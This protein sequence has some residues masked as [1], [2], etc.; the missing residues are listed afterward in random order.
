MSSVVLLITGII[1]T[2]APEL[3]DHES[4]DALRNLRLKLIQDHPARRGTAALKQFVYLPTGA[5]APRM[6][7]QTHR[8][9]VTSASAI[10]A[11]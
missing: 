5:C 7:K 3:P 1:M 4:L 10:T 9:F 8:F 2:F 11:L 6:F